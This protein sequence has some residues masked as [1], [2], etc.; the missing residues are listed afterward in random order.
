MKSKKLV[1]VIVPIYN[2]EKYISRTIESLLAQDYQ[3]LEIVLVDDGSPDRCPEIIDEYASRDRR[4]VTI[5]QGNMGVSAA[6]NAGIKTASGNYV[7]FVDGDDWVDVDYVSYFVRMLENSGCSIGANVN[8]YGGKSGTAR[9]DIQII[10]AEQAIEWIY[11]GRLYVAVWNKIYDLALIK[12]HELMFNS[13]I[14]Y[15]EGM[16]FNIEALQLVEEVAIG[17]KSVYHQVFNSDSATR[18]FSLDNNLCGIRS[19]E[20]QK[21]KWKKWNSR[22]ENAWK[23]HRYFYNRSIIEGLV[24]TRTVDFNRDLYKQ[25]KSNLRNNASVLLFADLSIPERIVW[26]V[27]V[28]N[29]WLAATLSAIRFKQRAISHSDC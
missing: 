25:S 26:A 1:S 5:H 4:I 3:E 22:I 16:L 13:D 14:W 28:I 17:S 21:K 10:S 29:P 20:L 12:E 27:W 24:R 23:Y 8:N 15:G 6:R 9:A 2:V 18:S 11:S 7:M 19:L